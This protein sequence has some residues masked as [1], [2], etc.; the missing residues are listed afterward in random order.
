MSL[1]RINLP[2]K[3]S[4]ISVRNNSV[5]SNDDSVNFDNL[6]TQISNSVRHKCL[7]IFYTNADQFSNKK[8][9]LC[10][11]I[12]NKEPDIILITEVLP[13]A[14]C[15]TI[16]KVR[17]SLQGYTIFTNFDFGSST[18]KTDGIRG[19]ASYFCFL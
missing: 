15:H 10:M 19:V 17:L 1:R 2:D 14:H 7:D 9:D 8:D 18:H 3:C 12:T 6:S 4:N 5:Y 16:S 11:A 13:K